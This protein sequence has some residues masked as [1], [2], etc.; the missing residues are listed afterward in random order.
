MM[1]KPAAIVF[2]GTRIGNRA[3]FKPETGLESFLAILREHNITTID[4]AQAYGNSESA[5][6]QVHAGERFTLDTKW[7]P[8]SWTET[9]P[10]ATKS[11]IIET[12]EDSIQRLGAVAGTF[13]LHK[14]DPLTPF[15]E[16]LAAVNEAYRRGYFRRFGL[17]GFPPHEIEAVYNHCL[18][19]DYP[20]PA[21]YQGSYNPL[22]RDK[23]TA[24]LPTL[25]KL[26]MAFYAFGPSA[27]GF[28][29]KT[30]AQAA[31]LQSDMDSVSAT[32]RPYLRAPKYMEALAE[33]NAL[34]DA[35][36]CSA[37][38]LAY[39]WMTQHSALDGDKGDALI[40]GASS[41]EQLDE[42]LAGIERGSLSD[43]ACAGIQKIWKCVAEEVE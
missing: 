10:W 23:E 30:V 27:G 2:G 39:R 22:S 33:W 13:Y 18:E 34:A 12:A 3:L 6:G 4:T 40:I 20:L 9:T 14:M 35:E 16:T 43:E 42:T 25:R 19:R 15:P 36:G 17:S 11:R 5:L 8:S 24:L 1:R 26:G 41:P 29:G 7:S 37:A 32:C 31:R 38:D 28:L 21:V